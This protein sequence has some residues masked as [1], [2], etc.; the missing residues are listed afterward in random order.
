MIENRQIGLVCSQGGRNFLHLPLSG[1]SGRIRTVATTENDFADD[2]AGRFGEQSNFLD[3]LGQIVTPE[4][5]LDDH[6]AFTGGGTFKHGEPRSRFQNEKPEQ[7][8]TARRVGDEAL[9]DRH[10]ANGALG[11]S[12]RNQE[13]KTVK[14]Y[15]P[16]FSC[17]IVTGRAG[18][19]V[20]IAC[21]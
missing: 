8:K 7:V 19:T 5:E 12:V 18:T 21:L 6:R 10:S 2:S 3:L 1:E 11:E 15:S 13:T 20:E 4:I 14:C 9:K 16:P 17:V